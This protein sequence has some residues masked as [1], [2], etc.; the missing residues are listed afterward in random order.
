[1][2]S[3]KLVGIAEKAARGGL[4]LF[5]GNALSTI[6]LAIGAIIIARLLGPADYGRYALALVLPALLVSL[7]D[8]GMNSALVRF[9]ARLRSEGDYE[10]SNKAIKLGFVLKLFLSIA[11]FLICYFGADIIAATLLN[12]PGLASY[13]QLAGL[14]I[15]FQAIFDTA[16]N[17]FIGMDL[18]QYS[19]GIQIIYSV[20]KSTLAPALILFG[21]GIGGAIVGYIVGFV[22]AGA[23]GATILF[24]KYT[25]SV[26][27][28]VPE[29]AVKLSALLDYSLPLYVA[30]ILSVLLTQYQNI[31][32]ARFAD[33]IQIGNFNAAWNFNALLSILIYPI[34]TA[35][36]PMFSKMNPESQ[37]ND[38]ARGFVLA[39][40]YA[41]LA[42][43]PASVAVMVFSQDLVLLTYG[44]DYVL[45]PQY[46]AIV[47]ALYLLTGIGWVVIGGFLNGLAAT[48]TILKISA[49]TL[50]VY[51]PLGP[52]LTRFWGPYGLL[53]AYIFSNT[54]STL[55]GV[56]KVSANFDAR[57]DLRSSARIFLASLVAAIPSAALSQFNA[58][59]VLNLV[60]GGCLFL[61]TYLTM[62]PILGAVIPQD[63]NNLETILCRTR[64]V[65]IIL[66]PVLAYETRILSAL[67]RQQSPS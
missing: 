29:H 52:V 61:F 14:L 8:A 55:Y 27:E 16:S 20:L 7:A 49:L 31:V 50:A 17:S 44:K 40:K 24:T 28:V 15:V 9:S 59:G 62:A 51:L 11:A 19:A 35:I 25:R 41:S 67:G 64:A 2:S 63:I 23:V 12:R 48:R 22:V 10:A 56:R 26:S 1:M 32:L 3:D 45:A 18:M 54:A 5:V 38:L 33:N 43:I 37:R 53:I 30:T 39:V 34:S 6:I 13:L 65:A 66:R 42:L 47:S 36:F 58:A 21:L 57:P 4:F 60:A 46:L